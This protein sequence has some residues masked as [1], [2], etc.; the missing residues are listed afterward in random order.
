MRELTAL[1]LGP[2][3][4]WPP[5]SK[6]ARAA[7]FN[8]FGQLIYKEPRGKFAGYDVPGSRHPSRAAACHPRESHVQKRL[9]TRLPRTD[10]ECTGVEQDGKGATIHF[11]KPLRGTAPSPACALTRR[12]RLR[13]CLLCYSGSNSIRTTSLAFAGINSW[14]K[15]YQRKPIS[16]MGA[17]TFAPAQFSNGKIVIYPI[18]DNIDDEGQSAHQLDGGYSARHVRAERLEPT[19]QSRRLPASVPE[20]DVRLARCGAVIRDADQILRISDGRQGSDLQLASL[21]LLRPNGA[22]LGGFER[23]IAQH[24]PGTRELGQ[25]RGLG[26]G[27][28]ATRLRLLRP[29]GA[30]LGGFKRATAHHPPGTRELGLLHG[31]GSGR[32]ATRLRFLPPNGAALGGFERATAQHPPGTRERGQNR[33][34]GSGRTATRLRLRRQHGAALGGFDGDRSSPSRDTR[35]WSSPWPG[36]RTD[37][38]LASGSA[39]NRVRLWDASSG[40]LLN[41][42]QGHENWVFSVAW[43]CNTTATRLRL[44]R[45]NGA[46]LEASS[47]ATARHPPG[48]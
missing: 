35:T 1:G 45:P 38:D 30:A 4:G 13:W 33:G 7:F 47:G 37:S 21:R 24:P 29:N 19:W 15:V 2:Q 43:V 22:A 14:R 20:L 26:S 17:R 11:K 18:V 32:T 44:L 40:R 39:D 6:T 23:A 10:H 25:N 36:L 9:G 41:T 16:S 48:K 46:L 3:N 28:T 42:L 12:S 5:A 27:R 34:P 8:R 31:L